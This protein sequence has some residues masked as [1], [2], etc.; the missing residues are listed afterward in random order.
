MRS[1]MTI[2]GAIT[3]SPELR[4][5]SRLMKDLAEM[6]LSRFQASGHLAADGRLSLENLHIQAPQLKLD[7]S[8]SI[9]DAKASSLVA[10]PLAAQATL[11]AH[12]DIAIILGGMKLL[13]PATADGFRPVTEPFAVGGTVGEPD[14]QQLYD[15]LARGVSGSSGTWKLL[16]EKL[17][18]RI[19][20]PPAN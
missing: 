14:V 16:M 19:K 7:I 9:P 3:F 8:G 10:Q 12:G 5:L 15:V 1:S 11:A 6:P 13:G 18:E 17:Q 20:R 4:A 2:L